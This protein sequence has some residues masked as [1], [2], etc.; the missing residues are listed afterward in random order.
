[1]SEKENPLQQISLD[2]SPNIDERIAKEDMAELKSQFVKTI[3]KSAFIGI[4]AN[5]LGI[6]ESTIYR[7]MRDDREFAAEVRNAQS[8]QAEEIGLILINK[9]KED[10]DTQALIF[11][12]KT[13]GKNLGFDEKAPAVNINI[14]SQADFD[15]SGLS[16]SDREQLLALIRKSKQQELPEPE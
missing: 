15:M 13:L 7:W 16:M 10:K 9:A 8:R 12:C 14:N 1:M 6:K 3:A 4:T 11:L 5:H 2:R